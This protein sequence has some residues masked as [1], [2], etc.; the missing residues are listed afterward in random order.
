M[1]Y[2]GPP[3]ACL[4]YFDSLGFKCPPN[5]NAA[6][7]ICDV[8]CDAVPRKDH[9]HFSASQEL[10]GIWSQHAAQYAHQ[11]QKKA[12]EKMAMRKFMDITPQVSGKF[13]RNKKKRKKFCSQLALTLHKERLK[14]FR[15]R[16]DTLIPVALAC[17]MMVFLGSMFGTKHH[18]D[19]G[20]IS[21]LYQM[22][23]TLVFLLM[24]FGLPVS[25]L[26]ARTFTKDKLIFW[27]ESGSGYS[28]SAFVIANMFLDLLPIIVMSLLSAI[29]FYHLYQ[30]WV[31]LGYLIIWF[32]I[33]AFASAGYAYL[34]S[35]VSNSLGVL[36]AVIMQFI[37][38]VM[39]AGITPLL[40]A[41]SMLRDSPLVV[42]GYV[43]VG[44][45]ASDSMMI[46]MGNMC[47]VSLLTCPFV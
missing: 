25:F 42:L 11:V 29:L 4:N 3:K 36:V 7:F 35:L 6:D 5:N 17:A 41:S 44:Y 18:G 15:D 13:A 38:H 46:S 12:N 20:C 24:L 31:S 2:D 37:L 23:A 27:R 39:L 8:T 40:K 28:I 16:M 1:V 14:R 33:Y 30:P 21:K 45:M 34:F 10:P 43:S 32:I 26:F 47:P 9:P 22:S 19:Q